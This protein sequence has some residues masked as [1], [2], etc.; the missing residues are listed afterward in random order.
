MKAMGEVTR[1]MR[2]NTSLIITASLFLLFAIHRVSFA[3]LRLG[4]L[5]IYPEIG[6]EEMYRTNIYQTEWN[7][8]SDFITSILPGI[9]GQYVFGG[10]HSLDAGYSGVG[11]YYSHY[12]ENDYWK[13]TAWGTLSLRFNGGLDVS[14]E[15]RYINDWLE[16]SAFMPRQRHY[17]ENVS[18]ALA[19]YRF[20][21]RWKVQAY[22]MR[23]DYS[24]S[25]LRDSIYS[26]LSNLYGGALLYRFTPRTSGV[27]EYQYITRSYDDFDIYDST[28]NQVFVGVNFDPEGKLAGKAKLGYGWKEF[29]KSLP[30]RSTKSNTWVAEANLVQNFT[31]YTSLAISALRAFQDDNDYNNTPLYRTNASLTLQHFFTAKIGGTAVAGY[32]NADYQKE[33]VEPLLGV[34]KRREDNIYRT[35]IGGF[36]NI[37]KYLKVRLE[38]SYIK[39][40][41]NFKGYSFDEN[42]VMF[43]I[44]YSP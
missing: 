23:D 18:G 19:A 11:K 3:E 35:G 29:D 26:Y 43:R 15:H 5:K 30:G 6:I 7:T 34:F 14:A 22:Y 4:N 12:S 40:D 36:Y 8:K 2:R 27:V 28:V 33:T 17:V 32:E 16:R 10:K 24:M 41:S 38:Y 20:A 44:V 39:R 37:Q 13:N 9:R 21:D 42:M 31:K 1:M 25:S